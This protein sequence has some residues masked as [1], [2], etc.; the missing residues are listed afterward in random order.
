MNPVAWCPDHVTRPKVRTVVRGLDNGFRRVWRY[1]GSYPG[2]YFP[3][4]EVGRYRLTTKAWCG[5]RAARRVETV[6]VE[7][8]TAATTMS[9][10]EY[11]RIKRGMTPKQV[12]RIVGVRAFASSYRNQLWW[13]FDLMPFWQYGTVEFRDRR[14][15]RK[16]WNVGHD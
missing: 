16:A 1:R 10:A 7:E 3:R 14:L 9:H 15:V 6:R 8:K 13:T 12:R 11:R 4:V 2:R 5:K